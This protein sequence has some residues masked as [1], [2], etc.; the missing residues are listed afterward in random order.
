LFLL[1]LRI[2][3][4]QIGRFFG[5]RRRR[6]IDKKTSFE[7]GFDKVGSTRAPFAVQYYHFGM[8]FLLFDVELI[9]LAP[10][11]LGAG[12]RLGENTAYERVC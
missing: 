11:L 10:V 5:K 1:T 12:F 7:C 9:L 4:S 3:I 2:L 6:F 8:L